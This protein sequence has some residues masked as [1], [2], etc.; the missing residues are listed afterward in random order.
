MTMTDAEKVALAAKILRTM[1][2]GRSGSMCSVVR[3]H[4][5]SPRILIWA[6]M[7]QEFFPR[8]STVPKRPRLRFVF[9]M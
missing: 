1:L 5:H 9:V 2:S 7:R 3:T 8:F 4:C 6:P